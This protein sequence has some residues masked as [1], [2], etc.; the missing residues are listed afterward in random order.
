MTRRQILA[1][2][3]AAP[4]V[5]NSRPARAN[6]SAFEKH[7]AGS[8]GRCVAIKGGPPVLRHGRARHNLGLGSTQTRLSSNDPEVVKKFRQKAE[9]YNMRTILSAPLPKVESE[10]AAYDVAVKAAKEA[11]AVAMHAA[12]TGRRYEA[13]SDARSLQVALRAVPEN[14]R[15]RRTGAAQAPDEACGR[16]S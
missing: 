14:G 12:L 4:T 16:K 9:G 5:F 6:G 7:G 3:A 15:S 11:G 10:V 1:V 8:H 2:A 13:V